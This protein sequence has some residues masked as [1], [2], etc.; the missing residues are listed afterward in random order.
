LAGRYV[1]ERRLG[2]GGMGVVYLA[3]ELRLDR[4]VAIKLLPPDRA[5]QPS[6]RDQFLREARTAARLSHP[7]IIPIFAVHEVGDFV[8]FAMAYVE[9]ETLGQRVRDTG[10]L[11]PAVAAP[12]LEQVARALAYAHARGV[13]HRDVKPDNIL[14]DRTTGRALVSDFGIARVGSGVASGPQRVIGTAEFMS[15]EQAV[16][17]PVDGRSD[18]YSLGV[19]GFFALSGGLPFEG[20]DAMTVLARHVADPPPPLASVAP[21][22]PARLAQ[23]IDRCLAKPP[24]ARFASGE[25][26]ADALAAALDRRAAVA[27]RAFL[28]EARHLSPATLLYG[29]AA[30]IVLPL[31]GM[32]FLELAEPLSRAAVG[33]AAAAIAGAP[34]AVMLA[35]VRRL[36]KAGHCRQDLVDALRAEVSHRREELTFLYGTGPSRLERALR[37]VAYLSVAVAAGIVAALERV[38]ALA[39]AV[40]VRPLFGAAAATALLAS[41]VARSRTEHRTDPKAE[42]R[43]RFWSGPVGRWLFALAGRVPTAGTYAD[44]SAGVASPLPAVTPVPEARDA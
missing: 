5:V 6:A 39:S 27:V 40:G 29:A 44:S 21:G 16:G 11:R 1:L 42:R 19:V 10:P 32:R 28:T 12:L 13:V 43:L 36:V 23:A 14:L 24:A 17:G 2:R 8:F 26:L 15:P 7:G 22:V 33:A 35:R 41:V 37:R 9:G 4:R 38:P 34:V 31:L 30:A 3:R 25:A 20:L 18:L